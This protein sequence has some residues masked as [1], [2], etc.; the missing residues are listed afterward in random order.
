MNK[1]EELV[2]L[3][4]AKFYQP[5][6]DAGTDPVPGQ[7]VSAHCVYPPDDPWIVK[8]HTYDGFNPRNSQ[9][10]VKRF[11]SGDRAHMPIAELKLRSDENLY[12]YKGKER[13]LVVLGVIKS[14]WANA[15]YDETIFSCAPL[16]TFKLRHPDEFK[17]KCAA[18]AYPDLFYLPAEAEGCSEEGVVRFE[19]IQPIA[20]RALR[21]YFAGNPS[22]PVALTD[23]AFALFVNH[24]ARFIFRRELDKEICGDMDTYRQLVMTELESVKGQPNPH[25][26]RVK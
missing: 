10:E 3:L 21:N 1:K 11:E 9:Y 22:Q 26:P 25:T 4:C 15:L 13:P 16:F 17:I 5:V 12:V 8:V 6:P 2:S 20:K 7:I 24:L 23:E 18:F 19:Y 14:R